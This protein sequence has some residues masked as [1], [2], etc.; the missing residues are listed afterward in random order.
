MIEYRI[1]PT[2]RDLLVNSLLTIG[3]ENDQKRN[4]GPESPYQVGPTG[5]NCINS[6]LFYALI[7]H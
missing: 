5:K 2:P 1:P 4:I 3:S 6:T 7:T